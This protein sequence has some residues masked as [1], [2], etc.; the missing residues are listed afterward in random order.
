MY[1]LI[2]YDVDVCKVS[3]INKFLKQY[4]NW[5]QNSVFEGELSNSDYVKVKKS[6]KSMIDKDND[7]ILIFKFRNKYSFDKET[8][9]TER[10]PVTNI[11]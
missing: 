8:I 11:V 10:S 2:V 3:K 4:M 7:S 1:C 6:L 5:I 9:G